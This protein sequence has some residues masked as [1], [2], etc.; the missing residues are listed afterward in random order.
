MWSFDNMYSEEE[1][2]ERFRLPKSQLPDVLRELGLADSGTPDGMWRCRLGSG[3]KAYS[4][5][6]MELLVVFLCRM[7][8]C[9]TW[10][11][12][13]RFLG[14]RSPT[15]YKAAFAFALEHLHVKFA[16]KMGGIS[17]WAPEAEAWASAIYA[18][19]PRF[20]SVAVWPSPY[21]HAPILPPRVQVHMRSFA[22]ASLTGRF[23]AARGLTLDR[24]TFTPGTTS[25]TASSFKVWLRRMAS[26]ST[27]SAPC[28]DVEGTDTFFD[29]LD[30][31]TACVRFAWPQAGTTMCTAILPTHC[32]GT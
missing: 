15:A 5:Q 11:L 12:L 24:S 30:F 16:S 25:R 29:G 14:C 20:S 23:V 18:A 9:N 8:S 13:V 22:S 19:G 21:V 10:S 6:P 7:S 32:P 26:S 28:Q 2:W 4:F 17:R 27:S 31:W 1:C 3:H